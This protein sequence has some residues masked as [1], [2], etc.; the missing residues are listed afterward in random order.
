M[1]RW[2]TFYAQDAS[3]SCSLGKWPAFKKLM[4]CFNFTRSRDVAEMHANM[5]FEPVKINLQQAQYQ[6]EHG[7]RKSVCVKT[8]VC[9]TYSIKSDQQ[10]LNSAAGEIFSIQSFVDSST[11]L[12]FNTK[13]VV[14]PSCMSS[15]L[16]C[17]AEIFY[18]LTLDALRAKARASFIDSDDKSDRRISRNFTIK[19]RE[20]KCMQETIM[21]S[22][23]IL[24]F[25]AFLLLAS[26]Q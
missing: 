20:R 9:F 17:P 25:L 4:W 13:S 19:D 14:F 24:I 12:F 6:C 5:T 18:N 2:T 21:M 8:E 23:S 11:D 7:G 16:A 15:H 3:V 26:Y 10:D 22:A 1:K